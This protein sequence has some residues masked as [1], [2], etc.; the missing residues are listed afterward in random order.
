MKLTIDREIWRAG[1]HGRGAAGELINDEGCLCILAFLCRAVGIPDEELIGVPLPYLLN[2][3]ELSKLP[4]A[5]YD[6]TSMGIV[7]WEKVFVV[8]SDA[9][10]IDDEIREAWL[11]EGFKRILDI[12]L[13]FVGDYD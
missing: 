13:V 10:D 12:D 11:A 5:L 6:T 9:R 4:R 8:I 7:T 3:F 1:P 2:G